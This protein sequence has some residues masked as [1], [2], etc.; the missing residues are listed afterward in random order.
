M[1]YNVLIYIWYILFVK[2]VYCYC[3]DVIVSV[4]FTR[5]KR[6]MSFIKVDKIVADKYLPS[7]V[8][9]D[10]SLKLQVIFFDF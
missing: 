9:F 7:I 8:F 1:N 4:I 5:W 2:I 6:L 3:R 10:K